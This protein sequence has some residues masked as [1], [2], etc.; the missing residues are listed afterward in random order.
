MHRQAPFTH[1]PAN[2]PSAKL[3]SSDERRRPTSSAQADVQ[4]G[5]RI[6]IGMPTPSNLPTS[7]SDKNWPKEPRFKPVVVGFLIVIIV[8]VLLGILLIS[9]AGKRIFPMNTHSTPSQT[10]LILPT[11]CTTLP[12]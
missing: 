2:G 1:D 7:P 3:E 6:Q 11:R 4:A 12:S 9:G 10:H 5:K 8:V